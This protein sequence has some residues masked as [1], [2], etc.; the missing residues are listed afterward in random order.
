[1]VNKIT[2]MIE[3]NFDCVTNKG[4]TIV[5]PTLF[6][7]SEA[8]AKEITSIIIATWVTKNTHAISELFKSLMPIARNENEQ[9][10]ICYILG[11]N[12]GKN[13]VEAP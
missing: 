11:T 13:T 8:R 3:F 4:E 10:Y 9:A 6:K 1:M 5:Y 12:I 7:I 2:F